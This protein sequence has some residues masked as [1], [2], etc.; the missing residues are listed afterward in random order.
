MRQLAV[1]NPIRGCSPVSSGCDNCVAA[2][3][4]SWSARRGEPY[5]ELV[6]FT[7]GE[8]KWT[9]T[10]RYDPDK[11][12][13][14][15]RW[16][17]PLLIRVCNAGDLFHRNVSDDMIRN[18]FFTM[19]MAA[20]HTFE[21]VTKF[22]IRM[23]QWF[24]TMAAAQ[25]AAHAE[26]SDRDWPAKNVR[27][28]ISVENQ[29]AVDDR[30]YSLIATPAHY[31]F[32]EAEPLLGPV[33]LTSVPCP[34]ARKE[35]GLCSMCEEPGMPGGVCINGYFNLLE[36]GID[37]VTVGCETGAKSLVR[38]TR[39]EWVEDL[40]LQCTQ[41]EIMMVDKQSMDG[42]SPSRVVHGLEKDFR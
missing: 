25:V 13:D 24:G 39:R 20:Q 6:W 17:E 37:H 41:H 34:E 8:W 42:W 2:R 29:E 12:R 32:V 19:T 15:L 5:D 35:G 31:R 21:V 7:R 36:Q 30:A 33:D 28:G 11:L 3:L 26:E 18:V 9:G 10:V 4:G 23:E 38:P 27:I 40:R 1:W 16:R 22:A 14:P